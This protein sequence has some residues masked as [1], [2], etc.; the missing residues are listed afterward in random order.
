MKR[1]ALFTLALVFIVASLYGCN[2]KPTET[3]NNSPENNVSQSITDDS[4]TDVSDIGNNESSIIIDKET[5]GVPIEGTFGEYTFVDE[6]DGKSIVTIYSYEQITDIKTRRESGE[7]FYLSAEELTFIINDTFSMFEQYA[8]IRVRDLDGN[9]NTYYGSNFYTSDEYYD[10]FNSTEL[11]YADASFDYRMDVMNAIYDRISV[12]NSAVFESGEGVPIVF[13]DVS[14]LSANELSNL[15]K[16]YNNFVIGKFS[17]ADKAILAK[18]TLSAYYFDFND[19]HLEYNA[20]ISKTTDT[21]TTDLL[22]NSSFPQWIGET[23]YD[24]FEKNVIVELW[25]EDTKKLISRIRIDEVNQPDEFA[26]FCKRIKNVKPSQNPNA[27]INDRVVDQIEKYRAVVYVNGVDVFTINSVNAFVYS[28]DGDINVFAYYSKDA[29]TES[30]MFQQ[31]IGS[32]TAYINDI[33]EKYLDIKF[34]S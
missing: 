30:V 14:K 5:P 10:C 23:K 15:T 3:S 7:Q 2:N 20:D 9:I 8:I 22:I 11:L 1:I 33:M 4:I 34:E 6:Q 21:P 17:D 18:H 32:L 13:S 24:V 27:V 31:G 16:S 26:E 12:L 19:R 28:P 25:S 29:Y